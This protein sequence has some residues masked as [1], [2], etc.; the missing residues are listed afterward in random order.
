MGGLLPR[1]LGGRRGAGVRGGTMGTPL[2]P[3]S[4]ETGRGGR[5]GMTDQGLG[6]GSG[7]LLESE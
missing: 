3:H 7:G 5:G 1:G 4:V 2:S 6:G